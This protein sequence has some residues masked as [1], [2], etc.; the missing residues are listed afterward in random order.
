[1]LLN[2]YKIFKEYRVLTQSS[3]SLKIKDPDC[4]VEPRAEPKQ[5]RLTGKK[6]K[7]NKL[8]YRLCGFLRQQVNGKK[9]AKDYRLPLQ[10]LQRRSIEKNHLRKEKRTIRS[11]IFPSFSTFLHSVYPEWLCLSLHQNAPP[12]VRESTCSYLPCSNNQQ[13]EKTRTVRNRKTISTFRWNWTKYY[14]IVITSMNRT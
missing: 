8:G 13:E 11:L 6:S 7:R 3:L 5:Q 10:P 2:I 1:M 4:L 12:M 14:R 9:K